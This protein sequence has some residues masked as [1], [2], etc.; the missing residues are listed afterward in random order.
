AVAASL[1][2]TRSP[3]A[4]PLPRA[5]VAVAEG[6][7]A[8]DG[9]P[10]PRLNPAAVN[11]PV[12]WADAGTLTAA[13]PDWLGVAGL[14]VALSGWLAGMRRVR[15]HTRTRAHAPVDARPAVPRR[16]RLRSLP[17]L[18]AAIY[19]LTAGIGL[20]TL[21]YPFLAAAVRPAAA[22]TPLNTPL[23]M[24]ALAALCFVALLF[25]VQGQAVSA[26][27][28]ALL[29]VLVAINS[30]LRFLEVSIP[31]PGGFT[32]I[33]F[34]IILTGYVYGG[35]FGFLMGALTLL[36][37]ALIT[38]GIGPWLPGQMFTAGWLGLLAPLAR[39]LVRLTGAAAGSRREVV[40]LAALAGLGGLFYGVAINL[41]FWPYMTGPADQYWQAGVSLLAA[42][43]R[44]AA[45]YVATS[46]V[47]DV[48][49][50]AG[51][52]L[53]M[54]LFGAATL[55]ALRRFQQR[56]DFAYQPTAPRWG[57][58]AQPSREGL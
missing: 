39:P 53:M 45:Y 10:V 27:L 36:V 38:G 17:W 13:R 40:A 56:F 29:G 52:V 5:A 54:A 14:T 11:A 6:V 19:G 49:A 12:Q 41:W 18:A 9:E 55:R 20:L 28:A 50:V 44:Y 58:A 35:R 30:L 43:Q 4:S 33:F 3:T 1:A 48:F 24:T 7:A 15:A 8:R 2:P 34:L 32:P 26:K 46:L 47:W 57:L 31:G 25:E 37:S 16:V 42:V 23:L 21:L 22:A 51:N